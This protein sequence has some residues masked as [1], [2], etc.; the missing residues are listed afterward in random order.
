[1]SQPIAI[2]TGSNRGLGKQIALEL[3]KRRF[4][5]VM[6][7]RNIQISTPVCNEIKKIS[8]SDSVDLIELDLSSIKSIHNFVQNFKEKY[9][10]LNVLINN[11]SIISFKS[12]KTIDGL[13]KV[14]ETNFFGPFLLT[15]LLIPLFTPGEEN[16][17]VNLSSM[18]YPLGRFKWDKINDYKWLKSYAVS[19][20]AT[21]LFTL[22]LAETLKDKGIMANAVHPGVVRTTIFSRKKWYENMINTFLKSLLIS[23]EEGARPVIYLAFSDEMK[24]KSGLYFYK[25]SEEAVSKKL[26]NPETRKELISRTEDLM[27]KK[28]HSYITI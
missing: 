9:G 6:A 13:D 18:I 3:S 26:N 2:V 22:E 16:R 8:D 1:M 5:V 27:N 28:W 4:L 14:M 12:G 10:H 23:V 7:C 19:K 11:A 21:L 15:R 24:G 25:L 20:Y 17:I